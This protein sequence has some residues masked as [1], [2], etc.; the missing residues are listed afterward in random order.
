MTGRRISAL[1]VALA[2]GCNEHA[3]YDETDAATMRLWH[4]DIAGEAIPALGAF[5]CDFTLDFTQVTEPIGAAL[6]RDRILMT[7]FVAEF[8]W[9]DEPGMFQKHIPLL[10]TSPTT[11]IAG[12]RYLFQG[13]FQAAQYE[14]FVTE[15]FMYPDGVQFLDRPEFSDAE[16]RDW[17]VIG[18]RRFTPVD[19]H[20]A[21]RTERFDTGRAHLGQELVLAKALRDRLPELAAE[22]EARG[23]GELHVLH[24][25]VDHKVQLVYFHPR[26]LPVAP[27]A[28]DVGAFGALV[29]AP[30]LDDAIEADLSL[31]RVFD[32]THFVLHVWLPYEEGDGGDA[33]LWPNSPPFPDPF[34]GDGVCVPSRAEDALSCPA[35]CTATCGDA[36]CDAGETIAACPS[37]CDVPLLP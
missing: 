13:R 31:T 16:C 4:A 9:P 35:D 30:V 11:A 14:E 18:A 25:F 27:D 12:G 17:S 22:A 19:T 37:D 26:V 24:D 36:E 1:C 32:V 6:E 8:T 2:V 28:P 10:Q 23:L 3:V 33:A 20:T 5:S 15:R 7:R 21:F 34:C 29:A